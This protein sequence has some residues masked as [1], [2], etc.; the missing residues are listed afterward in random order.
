[1]GRKNDKRSGQT[2][3]PGG[4]SQTSVGEISPD[5]NGPGGW[6]GNSGGRGKKEGHLHHKQKLRNTG[7]T[8]QD[9]LKDITI[10]GL[11]SDVNLDGFMAKSETEGE[12][13]PLPF[14]CLELLP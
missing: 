9:A 3:G 1:M 6:S 11:F 13:M 7:I 2:P 4:S 8:I 10:K 5:D 12:A 14:I